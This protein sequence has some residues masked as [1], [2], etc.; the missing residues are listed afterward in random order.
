M[1][2]RVPNLLGKDVHEASFIDY[3]DELSEDGG[4][5]R[6]LQVRPAGA[7]ALNLESYSADEIVV[8]EASPAENE[9]LADLGYADIQREA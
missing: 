8:V 2:V 3:P 7:E 9:E 4:T 1:R 5:K 6:V